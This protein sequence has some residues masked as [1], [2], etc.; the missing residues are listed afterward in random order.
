MKTVDIMVGSSPLFGINSIVV[1]KADRWTA[2]DVSPFLHGETADCAGNVDVS[3]FLRLAA[4]RPIPFIISNA[5]GQYQ[6]YLP[7]F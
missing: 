2:C 5:N 4:R 1:S 3:V 6:T 7:V